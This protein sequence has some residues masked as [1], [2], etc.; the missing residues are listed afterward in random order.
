MKRN[1][2]TGSRLFF[3]E[4]LIVLFFFLIIS[5]VCLRLFARAHT[6]TQRSDALSH[7]QTVA[8]SVAA[9]I[10]S[11]NT[12]SFSAEGVVSGILENA[13]A[14]FPDASVT[15]DEFFI[16]YDQNF[17]PCPSEKAFYT[18][19]VE[20]ESTDREISAD[21]VVQNYDHSVLYELPLS[22]YIPMTREEALQ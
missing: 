21:I 12:V 1:S 22:F 15:E 18:M 17:D 9:V 11:G 10:E 8:S 14:F 2:R 13:A 5:T 19:T 6:I 7:A 16:T 4:F 20:L 3:I